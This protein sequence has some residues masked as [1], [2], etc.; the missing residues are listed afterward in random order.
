MKRTRFMP[1]SYYVSRVFG[2]FRKVRDNVSNYFSKN[3]PETCENFN[4]FSQ[5]VSEN[6]Y[7]GFKQWYPFWNKETKV[8]PEEESVK[9]IESEPVTDSSPLRNRFS[10]NV[11]GF[12][13]S[14]TNT[15]SAFTDFRKP[16]E[17]SN[18]S[19][20]ENSESEESSSANSADLVV[21][22]RKNDKRPTGNEEVIEFNESEVP[23]PVPVEE[24]NVTNVTNNE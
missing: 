3:F 4:K 20:S 19:N 21:I 16:S 14:V 7:Y 15:L 17:S 5:Q 6:V 22:V 12:K 24:N 11:M 2:F 1:A 13:E 9:D 8:E 23:V 10:K 18:N